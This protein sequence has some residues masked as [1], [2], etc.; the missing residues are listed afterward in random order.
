[1]S[2]PG[3][4]GGPWTEDENAILREEWTTHVI[5][6]QKRRAFTRAVHARL[7]HR[8][9]IAIL[10]RAYI[11]GLADPPPTPPLPPLPIIE[12]EGIIVAWR[13][14]RAVSNGRD[15]VLRSI[16]T[17]ESWP[18]GCAFETTDIEQRPK[19]DGGKRNGVHAFKALPTINDY[20]Y[21]LPEVAG[22]TLVHGTVSL[23]GRV[24]EHERGYRA[25]FAYPQ[26][27][28]T[29]TGIDLARAIVRSYGIDTAA[30]SAAGPPV[31]VR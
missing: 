18:V 19:E 23:W 21:D 26:F 5:K 8:T 9:E 15:A 22:D 17:G 3:T 31:R 13:A 16:F 14:W 28:C 27:I 10:Q 6:N 4:Y 24:I 11:V 25:E 30:C 1:M 20:G 12:R 29:C 2:E 7:S